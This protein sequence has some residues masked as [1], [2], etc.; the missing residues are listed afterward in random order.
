[1][2][3]RD[4]VT[5]RS[6]DSEYMLE[7]WDLADTL[8]DGIK[9]LRLAGDTYLPQFPDEDA[10]GYAYRL[11]MTKYTNVY[12]DIVEALAAKPFEQDISFPTGTGSDEGAKL[13]A[14]MQ[15]I[16]ENIDGGGSD[17]NSFAS[18]VFFN[19][20]NSAIDW[21]F[22]D[23]P[24]VDPAAVRTVADVKAAGIRPYWSHVLARNMLEV[25]SE[26]VGGTEEIIYARM[27]EPGKPEHV[28]VIRKVNG[29]VTWYLLQATDRPDKL[30][31]ADWLWT[32]PGKDDKTKFVE[33]GRGFI[34]IGIVPL[35]PFYTGRRNGRTWRFYP[36]MR[37]AADLQIELY[38][39]ESGLKFAS[40]MTAYPMLAGNGVKPPMSADGKT[41]QKLRVGPNVVLYAPPDSSGN[42]GS[43]EFVEPNASSLKFLSDKIKD[44]ISNL[45][46]LGRQPLTAQ[47]GNLTVITTAVAAGKAKSAV[48][49]WAGGLEVALNR[50]LMITGKFL[51]GSEAPVTHV[52]DDFDEFDASGKDLEALR[53]ARK[54]RDLSQATYWRE[55]QRRRVLSDDFDAKTEVEAL[56][57]EAPSDNMN[58]DNQG[59]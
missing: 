14:D 25:R 5:C 18:A 53:E 11:R 56:A 1:M 38:Q 57:N 17:L 33:V 45:R 22:V 20:I 58:I 48:C 8:I 7:Y 28:R 35:V 4:P 44:T 19:G 47:S 26:V 46:E 43:W 6:D 39:E 54:N 40:N 31:D 32:A 34:S 52:F 30:P 42:V 15:A 51:G 49:A 21:I 55:L 27:L 59:P 37:D 10:T 41:P 50:A 24:A 3:M 16:V 29:V 12:R 2:Q 36:A 13:S 23:Y 9:A